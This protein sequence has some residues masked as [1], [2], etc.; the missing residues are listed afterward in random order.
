MVDIDLVNMANV[1]KLGYVGSLPGKNRDSDSWYTPRKYIE[2]VTDVLGIIE[3]DPYSS[4]YANNVINAT[5][6]YTLENP[7]DLK[8]WNY[9]TV[10][11]NPPYSSGGIKQAVSKF[12]EEYQKYKFEAIVLTNNATETK[13]FQ[14]LTELSSA[15]CFTNHR[16]SFET[17]DGKNKSNNTRGQVFF[18]FGSNVSGFISSFSRFGLVL[19]GGHRVD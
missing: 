16:I 2:A 11:M 17:V 8:E 12:V 6:F 19:K 3:L 4:E 5:V 18:Y 1:G 15:M 9:K 13:W 10:W 14:A 7:S